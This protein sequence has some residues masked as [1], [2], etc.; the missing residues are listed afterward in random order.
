[1]PKI[2]AGLLLYRW[3]K[4]KELE[5]FLAHPGGPFW[6]NKDEHAW[7]IPKGEVHDKEDL[8][9]CAKRELLE[10]TGVAVQGPF[11]YLGEVKMNPRKIV[12]VWACTGNWPGFFLRQHMIQIKWPPVVGKMI[13]IPEVDKAQ[14][15]PLEIAKKKVYKSLIPFLER[16][17]EK[18]K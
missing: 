8:L 4:N 6:K 15:F 7:D 10:E 17:P 13:T 14:Y 18:V 3:N 2:S 12:H 5:V 16:L 9:E 1:M 11:I